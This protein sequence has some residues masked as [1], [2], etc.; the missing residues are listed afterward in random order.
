MTRI[1]VAKLDGHGIPASVYP[2]GWLEWADDPE[3]RV[4]LNRASVCVD[5]R[6][7][8]NFGRACLFIA[9][10]VEYIG[11][12]YHARNNYRKERVNGRP[13]RVYIGREPEDFIPF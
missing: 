1:E 8:G 9:N 5:S 13:V 4:N 10:G 11:Q 6:N 7:K 12:G 2:P 3:R